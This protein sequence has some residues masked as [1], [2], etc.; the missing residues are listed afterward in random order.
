MYRCVWFNG[1]IHLVHC[2]IIAVQLFQY[3][4]VFVPTFLQS[5]DLQVFVEDL[6]LFQ[7]LK[8][9]YIVVKLGR[10]QELVAHLDTEGQHA[11]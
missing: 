3:W 10:D 7:S 4:H 2:K 9:V 6:R 11:T 8:D 5:F 1:G